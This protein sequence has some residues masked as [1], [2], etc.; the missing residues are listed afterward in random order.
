[1][2]RLAAA[3]LLPLLASGCA[4]WP[5]AG[6]GSGQQAA[7][8]DLLYFGTATPDGVVS[9]SDWQGFV[10]GVVTP[11]FPD[12]LS[13]WPAS[14][15]W[16][17]AAGP[18]VREGSYVLNLVHPDDTKAEAAIADIV[19]TYKTRFRQ[20]AVMRVRAPACISF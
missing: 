19:R 8:Q 18:I 2:K 14:G 3:L 20:E 4:Q 5:A 11:R 6:C 12:G 10:D 9:A 13:V 15:Q 16:K 7:V 1:M 17:S